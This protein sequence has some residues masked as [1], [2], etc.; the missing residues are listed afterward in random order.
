MK[1]EEMHSGWKSLKK[2]ILYNISELQNLFLFYQNSLIQQLT[3]T[4]IHPMK[5]WNATF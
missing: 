1:S 2:P 5:G 4:K 3:F